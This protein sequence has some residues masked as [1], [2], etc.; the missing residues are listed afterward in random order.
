MN[1]HVQKEMKFYMAIRF[2][3]SCWLIIFLS[4]CAS[5]GKYTPKPDLGI[6]VTKNLNM[7]QSVD[8][9]STQMDSTQ[10]DLNFKNIIVDYHQFSLSLVRAIK[11]ELKR[12]GVTLSPNPEKKLYI[13]VTKIEIPTPGINF[14][15]NIE[16]SVK[17]GDG[18]DVFFKTTRASYASPFNMNT[19]P[20]KPLDA[21]FREMVKNILS[22]KRISDYLR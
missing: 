4:S 2:L 22:D 10:R 14:R 12:N 8:V 17:T 19:F 1:N 18:Q 21:A 7:A 13:Q 5:V 9:I 11:M 15:A 16:A 3:F 20:T 6:G